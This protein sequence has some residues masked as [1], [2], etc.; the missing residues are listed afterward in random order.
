MTGF[1][2]SWL[3]WKMTGLSPTSFRILSTL[4]A[5]YHNDLKFSDKQNQ[6]D[7]GLHCLQLGMHFF[8]ALPHGKLVYSNFRVITSI[9]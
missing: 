6:P 8:E 4:N 3:I 7:H 2:L 9:I 5:V 1:L